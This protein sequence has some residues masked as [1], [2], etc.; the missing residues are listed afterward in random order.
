MISFGLFVWSCIAENSFWLRCWL[1]EEAVFYSLLFMVHGLWLE[2]RFTRATWLNIIVTQKIRWEGA[3]FDATHFSPSLQHDPKNKPMFLFANELID[4][5]TY[6]PVVPI[7]THT[8]ESN[9]LTNFCIKVRDTFLRRIDLN[10]KRHFQIWQRILTFC[11]LNTQK[12]EKYF[13]PHNLK[14]IL[15]GTVPAL[16]VLVELNSSITNTR[17]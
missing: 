14:V 6:H 5:C 10:H 15:P 11:N 16:W 1:W 4:W 7:L 13:L 2:V 12:D 8:Y 3:S 17:N 9:E